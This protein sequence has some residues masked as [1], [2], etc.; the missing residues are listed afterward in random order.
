LADGLL[1]IFEALEVPQS[2]ADVQEVFMHE[3]I[4]LVV[5]DGLL[6]RLL[7]VGVTSMQTTTSRIWV[8]WQTCTG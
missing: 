3:E 5:V 8:L 4:G 7:L 2:L 6:E 1:E